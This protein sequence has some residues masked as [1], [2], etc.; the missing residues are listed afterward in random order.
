MAGE[1]APRPPLTGELLPPPRR[2]GDQGHRGAVFDD[3]VG[4]LRGYVPP[5]PPA[6]LGWQAVL[7][8]GLTLLG[9]GLLALLPD[10]QTIGTSGVFRWF[11]RSGLASTVDWAGSFAVAVAVVGLVGLLGVGVIYLTRWGATPALVFM[12]A[13]VLVGVVAAAGAVLVWL[14]LL[15]VLVVNLTLWAVVIALC[16]VAAFVVLSIFGSFAES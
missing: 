14:Y 4:R 15:F 12:T 11:D 8:N 2:D 13:H 7:G 10:K 1:L 6:D 5:P 9:A 3:F 16:A